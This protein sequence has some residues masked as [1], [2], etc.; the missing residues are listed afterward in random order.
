MN[1]SALLFG[2]GLVI[3]LIL[4]F[5]TSV[6]SDNVHASIKNR[7]GSGKNLTLHCQSK[8]DDLGEQ[9]VVD[10]DEFGWDFSV[11]AWGS[12]LFYCDMGWDDVQEYHFDAYSFDRDFARC[13]TQCAW[14]V[15]GEGMYGLNGQTGFWEFAYNWPS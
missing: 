13:E 4:G 14:L 12:T 1:A 6:R 11:N 3:L 2:N 10:G 7:L 8:D 9:I 5:S 15:S